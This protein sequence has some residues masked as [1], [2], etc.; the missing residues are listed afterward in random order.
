MEENL[1]K[2]FRETADEII[3]TL[4]SDF[5]ESTSEFM[6]ESM[7]DARNTLQL[8]NETVASYS[9]PNLSSASFADDTSFF[10]NTSGPNDVFEDTGITGDTDMSDITKSATDNDATS[11]F[12]GQENSVLKKALN[13]AAKRFEKSIGHS[14]IRNDLLEL[15]PVM[16]QHL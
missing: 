14:N 4:M 3:A 1:E 2:L 13:L 8:L 15:K 9:C 7:E 10:I 6:S 11:F 16:L 12:F 5:R